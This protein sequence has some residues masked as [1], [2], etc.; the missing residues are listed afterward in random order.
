MLELQLQELVVC[1]QSVV[2]C[3]KCASNFTLAFSEIV[4]KLFQILCTTVL[5]FS[6]HHVNLLARG[7]RIIVLVFLVIQFCDC[8]CFGCTDF[9]GSDEMFEN[10]AIL[11]ELLI[12]IASFTSS[13]R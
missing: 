7:Q 12:G 6:A 1:R 8:G 13:D 10:V 3:L 2:S 9:F 11:G 4:H 5:A